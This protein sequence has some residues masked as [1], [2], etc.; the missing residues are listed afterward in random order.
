MI[1]LVAFHTVNVMMQQLAF[2]T[3]SS[4][5]DV[6]RI[7]GQEVFFIFLNVKMLPI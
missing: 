3:G 5:I 4:A 6:H 2:E 7:V 1:A